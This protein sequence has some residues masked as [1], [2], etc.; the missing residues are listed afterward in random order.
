[1][2]LPTP[3]LDDRAF[4]DI[5]EEA[6]RRIE[7]YTP[8]W[9]DHNLSDPGITLIE[10]FAWMTD[11]VLYRLNRVPDKHFIKF[12]ELIGMRLNEA[13]PARV[14]MT[15]W[16]STP[17]DTTIVIPSGTEVATTRTETEAAIVFST[18]G[19][20]EIRVPNLIELMTSAAAQDGSRIF[21]SRNIFSVKAGYEGFP[22]FASDTPKHDDAVYLGFDQDMSH[23]LIGIELEVDTAE[24]AGIDPENPPYVWEVLSLDVD[25]NWIPVEKDIDETLGLNRSGLIR[26]H[27]PAMRRAARNERTAYWLRLRLDTSKVEGGAVYNVSPQIRRLQVSSWGGTISATNVTRTLKEVLGRS[28]GSP[29]QRFYLEH[30]PLVARSSEEYLTVKPEDGEEE[31]WQE[32]TDFANSTEKDKH[33]TIDSNTGEVRLGPALQRPDGQVRRFGAIPPKGAMLIMSGYRYGGGLVG[34]VAENSINVLKTA[35]PYVAQVRNRQAATGGEDAESLDYAKTRVPGYLRS[36]QRAVTGP[37]FEYLA[38]EEAARGE[39]GRVHCLQPP[40]TNRGEIH[41]LVIPKVPR[42]NGFISPESL[43]LPDDLRQR[44][45]E[46]LDERRLLSTRLEVSAPAYQWVETEVRLRVSPTY[47]VEKVRRAVENKLFDFVN[48][49]IGGVEGKGWPF[50]RDLFIADVMSV[51]LTVAGVNFIRSVALYPIEYNN[52]Q[53][54][55]GAETQE[56]PVAQRG[57]V[58]SY[59]HNIMTI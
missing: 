37:D 57:I 17:Q 41:L 34:N 26:L 6:R 36:L 3:R 51:L 35:L 20:L 14:P 11:I 56:I 47:D 22:A 24:G 31:K 25:Q 8:E 53:F 10:L 45:Q 1:M 49:L 46:F 15:F 40:L 59:Q 19:R 52:G 5:V 48:P 4:D 9:T 7:L 38:R 50:G 43:V 42:P 44:I 2:S 29:G 30:S 21:T 18:D 28:D 39:V 55:R 16:L 58:V 12:M 33:F 54:S 32:V 23:H 27:L 13:K